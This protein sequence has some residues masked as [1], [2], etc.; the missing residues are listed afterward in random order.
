MNTGDM[1]NKAPVNEAGGRKE[2]SDVPE[3]VY[4]GILIDFS[5]F[6]S[7]SSD[8]WWVSW[9][10][11]VDQG[12]NE[13]ALLER[14][15]GIKESTS[16]YIKA[17]FKLILG[18]I[19]DWSEMADEEAGLTGS[20]RAEVKG[21]RVRVRQRSR[22]VDG[23]VWKDVFINELLEAPPGP[24]ESSRS[25]AESKAQEAAPV[26]DDQ[27]TEAQQD[28]QV[29]EAK[30]SAEGWGD[31]ECPTCSGAGCEGCVSF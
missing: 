17:D 16:P 14:Y 8:E 2:M 26:D 30:D 3:G 21:A 23:D 7:R 31:P 25:Y 19:P 24:H 18:R 5:C 27:L 13:G 10:I 12:L 22:R 29:Q 4:I 1:W 11:R 15:M 28:V 6:R 20:V 9:W